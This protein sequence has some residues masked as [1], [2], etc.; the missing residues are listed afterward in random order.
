MKCCGYFS[1]WLTV[2]D[3]TCTVVEPVVGDLFKK[4]HM[5]DTMTVE[6]YN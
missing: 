5:A 4:K 6:C 3:K 2:D 1:D